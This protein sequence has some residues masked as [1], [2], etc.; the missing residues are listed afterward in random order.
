MR[1]A[2]ITVANA[3]ELADGLGSKLGIVYKSMTRYWSEDDGKTFSYGSVPSTLADLITYADALTY[4][5]AAIA[6]FFFANGTLKGTPGPSPAATEILKEANGI[7]DIFGKAYGLPAGAQGAGAYG[8]SRPFQTEPSL[9]VFIGPDFFDVQKNNVE[10]LRGPVQDL[11]NSPSFPSGHT[12]FGYSEALL[13]AFL[14]PQRY[15]QMITR[16]AEYANGR[17]VLGAHYAMDVIGGRTLAIY[18]IAQLLANRPGYVGVKRGAVQIDDFQRA[19]AAART[20]LTKALEAS[21]AETLAACAAK[22]G[23]RFKDTKKDGVFYDWTLTYGLPVVFAQNARGV[24][25]IEKLAPEAGYLLTA[26]FPY[27]SLTQADAILS[28][29]EGPGGGFLDN[30]S[31][32][33]VYS[34]LNLYRAAQQA[35]AAAPK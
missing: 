15:P 27:L 21:C 19:L 4:G 34:R 11:T 1:D 14:V 6:K 32:F 20:D 3:N 33:G 17:I 12:T 13:L 25:D 31:P 5:D 28:S 9:T 7:T 30:G 35:L 8:N 10:Y 2:F 22:D 23:G 26:A 16:A 24:E 18:D 29:T